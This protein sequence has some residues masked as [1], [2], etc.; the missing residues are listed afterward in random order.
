MSFQ[1]RVSQ[2]LLGK[3]ASPPNGQRSARYL[4]F[5]KKDMEFEV[6]LGFQCTWMGKKS[7]VMGVLPRR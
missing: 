3:D 5:E 7:R 4:R 1:V 6:T 2:G